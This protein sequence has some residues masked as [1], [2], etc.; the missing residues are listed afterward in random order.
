ML[1]HSWGKF[2]TIE[3]SI[4]HFNTIIPSQ[5]SSPDLDPVLLFL[6]GLNEVGQSKWF[7][8]HNAKLYC[9]LA[10]GVSTTYPEYVPYF[11]KAVDIKY[12]GNASTALWVD[13]R[14]YVNCASITSCYLF[15]V[16]DYDKIYKVV[17]DFMCQL[18]ER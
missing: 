17:S 8:F 1:N 13:T 12:A 2:I 5:L 16:S 4:L 14:C 10:G 18:T 15:K 3:N 11:N 9:C 6:A 7:A